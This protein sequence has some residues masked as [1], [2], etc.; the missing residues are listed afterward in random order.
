M[1]K[2]PLLHIEDLHATIAQKPVLQGLS[3]TLYPG[4]VHAL[5]GRNGAGKSSLAYTLAGHPR[6]QVTSGRAYIKGEDLLSMPIEQ[7]AA[8]GLFMTFQQPIAIPGVQNIQFLKAAVDA[9][10]KARQEPPLTPKAWLALIKKESAAV[11][12]D[13]TL[14]KRSLHDGFSGGEK[15]RNEL[16]QMR[17][18]Q[19]QVAILDEID[20]GLDAKALQLVYK[21]IAAFQKEQRAI[22]LITHYPRLLELVKPDYVHWLEGGAIRASGDLSL[23][24]TIWENG[25]GTT[26]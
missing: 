3:L 6:Y 18:L 11:D 20:S 7:R 12:L 8:K 22:L 17:L 13:F 25:Y 23:A 24:A 26:S 21:T 4:E 2:L 9:I 16:L 19:P 10:R 5:I 15:K 1:K 14:L